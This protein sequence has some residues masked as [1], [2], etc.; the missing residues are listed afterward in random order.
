[1]FYESDTVLKS[2]Q[3]DPSG[4]DH[5]GYSHS[6]RE[7]SRDRQRGQGEGTNTHRVPND[8]F[9]ASSQTSTSTP[10]FSMSWSMRAGSMMWA[11]KWRPG[12]A[13]VPSRYCMMQAT[14]GAA[15]R[16]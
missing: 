1:M 15:V 2:R 5:P 6:G 16:K 13:A 10:I 12:R 9:Q 4:M 8:L 11:M 3:Q 7:V 14:V